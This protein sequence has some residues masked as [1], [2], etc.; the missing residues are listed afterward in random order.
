MKNVDLE[1]PSPFLDQVY[2]GCTQR[3]CQPNNILFDEYRQMFESTT[4]A[5]AVV[6]LLG[7]GDANATIAAWSHDMEGHA[8]K[9]VERRCELA[10]KNS[11]QL[12]EVSEPCLDD[13]QFKPEELQAVGELS[14][15]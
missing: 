13:H 12:Y 4:S 6:K 3:E 15:V 9:C 5:G 2:L 8:K 14:K 7:S 10:T 11:E 1:K